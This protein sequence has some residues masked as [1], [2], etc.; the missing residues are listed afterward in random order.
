MVEA[1][2][3]GRHRLIFL[4][5]FIPVLHAKEE[6]ASVGAIAIKAGTAKDARRF[7]IRL[8]AQNRG[9]LFID[10]VGDVIGG[11]LRRHHKANP[12]ALI[13]CGHKASGYSAKSKTGEQ[14]PR[15]QRAHDHA[16]VRQHPIEQPG[17]KALK[18]G[19]V[20][21]ERAENH[22]HEIAQGAAQTG[23]EDHRNGIP[24]TRDQ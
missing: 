17:V 16:A 24:D 21:V 3:D 8:A 22:R 12:E 1:L 6:Q 11:A 15:P 10:L 19:V 20:G 9:N 13:F 4:G 18:T 7:Y 14:N 23:E 2:G 5:P